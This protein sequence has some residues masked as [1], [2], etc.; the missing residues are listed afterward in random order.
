MNP[1]DD[2][3]IKNDRMW[4]TAKAHRNQFDAIYNK[5][6]KG[7]RLTD[8]DM[9]LVK[10]SLILTFCELQYRHCEDLAEEQKLNGF[11]IDNPPSE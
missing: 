3:H 9:T 11:G 2:S 8:S 1:S 5:I 10:Y 7:A 4:T 6:R